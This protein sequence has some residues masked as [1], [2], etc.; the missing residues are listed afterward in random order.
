MIFV[1]PTG[2]VRSARYCGECTVAIFCGTVSFGGPIIFLPGLQRSWQLTATPC[3][4]LV[5]Y[6]LHC[7]VESRPKAKFS[8]VTLDW[9]NV[10]YC[11]A[12][13]SH[14]CWSVGPPTPNRKKWG[15]PWIN[16]TTRKAN[17]RLY[18]L[19]ECREASLSKEVG[20]TIW[21]GCLGSG[22]QI[23]R[24]KDISTPKKG[25]AF[26]ELCRL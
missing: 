17:K 16:K 19:S 18:Y 11:T 15:L 23:S 5:F 10:W 1:V 24:R 21:P 9:V 8:H 6:W 2:C 26:N 22:C 12:V 25:T 13:V 20:V 14:V 4:S 7:T 3:Y